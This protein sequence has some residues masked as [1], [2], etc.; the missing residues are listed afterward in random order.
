[1]FVPTILSILSH[2]PD[3]KIGGGFWVLHDGS[4]REV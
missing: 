4:Q 3:V 2:L 1:M